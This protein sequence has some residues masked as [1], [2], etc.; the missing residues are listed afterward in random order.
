MKNPINVYEKKEGMVERR[1]VTSSA[2]YA[3]LQACS[4]L[5]SKASARG[6]PSAAGAA[7]DAAT[8]PPLAS[9]ESSLACNGLAGFRERV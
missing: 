8:D 9:E 1:W 5:R 6:K 4:N 2:A 3:L 7:A